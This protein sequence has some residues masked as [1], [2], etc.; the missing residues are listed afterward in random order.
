MAPECPQGSVLGPV[1]FVIYVND[2]PEWVRSILLLFADDAKLY[3]QIRCPFDRVL[4]QLDVRGME[5][6]S[7]LW[8]LRFQPPKCKAMNVRSRHQPESA[9]K[10]TLKDATSNTE[11]EL[12]TVQSEKD[13]GVTMDFEL[14]FDT[15]ISMCVNKANRLV[16]LIRRTYTHLGEDSF[17]LLFKSL[18]RPHL[19]YAVAAWKPWKRKH[20]DALEGVQRR[21][22]RQIPTLKGLEYPERLRRLKMTTLAFR[23]L[24]GDMIETY[25]IVTGVYDTAASKGI[26]NRARNTRTRG[27][28][29]KL[30]KYTC[31]KNIRLH[32]F[33]HRVVQPWN[34]LPDSVVAAP[35]V[36][37]F[38]RRLD[39]HWRHH[40][41]RWDHTEPEMCETSCVHSSES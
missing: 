36:L 37:A 29:H 41:L 13:V 38:E 31:N 11:V 8:L 20:I 32:T 27:H 3:R 25:K 34:S 28:R 39:K 35:S 15:H 18:V 21:A 40:P 6:W 10:Y 17:R 33:S 30:E 1:I 24:R 14:D 22:T 12:S 16:G 4:L 19:E 2:V 5:Q 23:R 9:T 26:L 7:D